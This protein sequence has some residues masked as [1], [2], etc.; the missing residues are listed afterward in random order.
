MIIAA[1]YK[2]KRVP[3]FAFGDKKSLKTILAFKKSSLLTG[4]CKSA[5]MFLEIWDS[6]LK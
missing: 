1:I 4:R 3:T 5:N 6:W 2:W